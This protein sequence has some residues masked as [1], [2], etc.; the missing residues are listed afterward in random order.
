MRSAIFRVSLMVCLVVVGQILVIPG[1]SIAQESSP[2]VSSQSVRERGPVF[3]SGPWRISIVAAVRNAGINAVGLQREDDNDWLV[4]VADV[5]NWGDQNSTLSLDDFA[6][7]LEGL[8]TANGGGETTPRT[9][10]TT[11]GLNLRAGPGTDTAILTVIPA[12]A[13]VILSGSESA[14]FLPVQYEGQDG[15]AASANLVVQAPAA[16]DPAPS[17]FA[18]EAT[19]EVAEQLNSE[20]MSDD[21]TVDFNSDETKRISLA[22]QIPQIG[23]NPALVLRN[24]LPLDDALEN[25]TDLTVLPAIVPAPDLEEVSVDDV[26]DGATLKVFLPSVNR[27]VDVR[28]LGVDSPVENDC[29]AGDAAS[30]LEDI[31]GSTVYLE[32][33][34]GDPDGD[35]TEA[36]VWVEENGTKLLVNQRL[37]AQGFAATIVT[38]ETGGGRYDTWLGEANRVAEADERGLWGA[39]T[40]PHGKSRP[41]PTPTPIPPTP[42]PTAE[43]RKAAYVPLA[44]VREL[45]IRPGG[46]IGDEIAFS[47]TILTIQVAT[48]GKVFVVGD[49]DPQ[50]AEAIFQVQVPTPDGSI[51]TVFV[52]YDGETTGI[53]EGTFVTVYGTVIGTQTGTNAFG[54][55]ITQPLI[56]AEF[57]DIG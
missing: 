56:I 31:A 27:S 24:T 11:T 20:P 25:D 14:G 13:T 15:W 52:G 36:F 9:A 47:G 3:V 2:T 23:S 21:A 19:R 48:P 8:E 32:R 5:T 7:R 35:E 16:S 1:R 37:I 22:F 49:N 53:F 29:F 38:S 28:L 6:I 43:E 54:G 50:A 51:E 33:V 42:T 34:G 30:A 12:G 26:V 40:G 4:V 45:A 10:T 41:K 39:C 18:G 44:D 57:V 17:Y 46:F 55:T